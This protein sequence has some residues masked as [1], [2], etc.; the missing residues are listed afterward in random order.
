M[1]LASRR[2]GSPRMHNHCHTFP[3]PKVK[4]SATGAARYP[5]LREPNDD[6]IVLVGPEGNLFCVIDTSG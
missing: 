6:V 3:A 2:F 5:R 4:G 1:S